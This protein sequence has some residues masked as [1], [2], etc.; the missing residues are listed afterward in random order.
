[1]CHVYFNKTA[2]H[3]VT[4]EELIIMQGLPVKPTLG[5]YSAFLEGLLRAFWSQR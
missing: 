2:V 3:P 5:L 4:G 1:M